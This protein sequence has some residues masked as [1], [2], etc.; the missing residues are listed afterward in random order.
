MAVLNTTS[1][2]AKPGA[3][4]EMPSKTVPSSRARMALSITGIALAGG[5]RPRAAADREPGKAGLEREGIQA[6][7]NF[8]RKGP[9]KKRP[10]RAGRFG[11]AGE[12]GSVAERRLVDGD[13]VLGPDALLGGE[14]GH[15]AVVGV[16]HEVGDRVETGSHAGIA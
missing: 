13:L 9:K 11:A 16:V 12:R 1:P 15:A 8:S 7:G 6:S 2:T 14:G 10:A 3:P 4:T 5:S